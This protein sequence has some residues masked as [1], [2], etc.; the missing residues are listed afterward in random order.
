MNAAFA[1]P[2]LHDLKEWGAFEGYHSWCET[3]WARYWLAQSWRQRGSCSYN[4][5]W[6]QHGRR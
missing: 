6:Y 5:R 4:D 3:G 1:F 2:H